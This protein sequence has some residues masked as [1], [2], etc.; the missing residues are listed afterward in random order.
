LEAESGKA[1]VGLEVEIIT[2]RSEMMQRYL[3]KLV[4]ACML[5]AAGSQA[6]TIQENLGFPDMN[7]IASQ[8]DND[9]ANSVWRTDDVAGGAVGGQSF[10][11]DAE[12]TLRSITFQKQGTKT[13]TG[14]PSE[15]WLFIGGFTNSVD[16][17]GVATSTMVNAST[18]L[19]E[20]FDVSGQTLVN[21]MYYSL[22][23]DS[24]LTLDAG[25]YAYEL[26]FAQ[27]NASHVLTMK[28]GLSSSY[29]NGVFF[30]NGNTSEFPNPTFTD[31]TAIGG[32]YT[33][34]LHS[35]VVGVVPTVVTLSLIRSP[36]PLRWIWMEREGIH[37]LVIPPSV[38]RMWW[39]H[40]FRLVMKRTQALSAT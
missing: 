23:F 12:T 1:K 37:R 16:T 32:D 31:S 30:W 7:I 11:L 33:F 21:E 5:V 24:D 4:A 9:G 28:R 36:C 14:T 39:F 13:F 3:K 40:P 15:I 38:A 35:E 19:L 10:K 2:K 34:G 8:T 20:T 17:N 26:W 29:T 18:N 25:T 6:G 27:T 22:N